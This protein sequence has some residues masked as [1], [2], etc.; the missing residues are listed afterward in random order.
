MR[1]AKQDFAVEIA[2]LKGQLSDALATLAAL[3]NAARESGAASFTLKKFLAR[4]QLSE[5]QYHKLR[6]QGRGPRVMSVGTC[7]V[8][9]SR[10]AELDWIAARETEAEAASRETAATENQTSA[11][12]EDAR[13]TTSATAATT[14]G[15]TSRWTTTA[16]FELRPMMRR[17]QVG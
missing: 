8:R 15:A 6:R 2:S 16:R 14:N 4:N 17:S 3:A 5:S 12:D 1:S 13:L 11:P 10:Q 9:I 7:G